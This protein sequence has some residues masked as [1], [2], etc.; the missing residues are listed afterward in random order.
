MS[1]PLFSIS[2]EV[3]QWFVAYSVQCLFF[4]LQL[5][6]SVFKFVDLSW[7]WFSAQFAAEYTSTWT[8]RLE[9]RGG[10]N[11]DS[12]MGAMRPMAKYYIASSVH[13][14]GL[15]SVPDIMFN[16][17]RNSYEKSERWVWAKCIVPALFSGTL[18]GKRIFHSK[19]NEYGMLY[20]RRVCR[21]SVLHAPL[22]YGPIICFFGSTGHART[23]AKLSKCLEYGWIH[24]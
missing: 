10:T 9:N 6:S 17:R 19:D 5:P 20:E 1:G 7:E 2:W 24:F 3:F 11:V 22:S 23:G 4:S 8:V 18:N 21:S 13:V 15:R 12:P 16:G 14:V